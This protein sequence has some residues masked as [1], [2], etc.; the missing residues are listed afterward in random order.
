MGLLR[1]IRDIWRQYRAFGDHE[2][3]TLRQQVL[4]N[5]E[6][7]LRVKEIQ[8]SNQKLVEAA[9]LNAIKDTVDGM[10]TIREQAS[11][12]STA[13]RLALKELEKKVEREMAVN[14]KLATVELLKNVDVAKLMHAG[15]PAITDATED[16]NDKGGSTA[17]S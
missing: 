17:K 1:G 7:L 15:N 13:A 10:Q 5:R 11:A 14:E 3:D 9:V 8:E 2:L 12:D 4:A 16:E 6:T